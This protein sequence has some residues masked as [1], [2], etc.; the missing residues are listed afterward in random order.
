[1]MGISLDSSRFNMNYESFKTDGYCNGRTSAFN[2]TE[3]TWMIYQESTSEMNAILIFFLLKC[4]YLF[5]C[6]FNGNDRVIL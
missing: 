6:L 4:I 3:K 1:M 5:V 2:G